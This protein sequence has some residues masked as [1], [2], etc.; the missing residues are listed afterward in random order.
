MLKELSTSS[1]QRLVG[2]QRFSVKDPESKIGWVGRAKE[3]PKH[4]RTTKPPK[5]N[6]RDEGSKVYIMFR[7]QIH[8]PLAIRMRFCF[9]SLKTESTDIN[10]Q[11][12]VGKGGTGRLNC[13][14]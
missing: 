1:S 11:V 13:K 12:L 9:S 3:I 8:S 10:F 5:D 6:P 14:L 7:L 4:F 2:L